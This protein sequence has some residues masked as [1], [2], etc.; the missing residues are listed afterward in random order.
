MRVV[1]AVVIL[2]VSFP[3]NGC[4]RP[5]QA[6]YA[7]PLRSSWVNPQSRSRPPKLVKA[8]S[9]KPSRPVTKPPQRSKESSVKPPKPVGM[10]PETTKASSA[11]SPP[12]LPQRKSEQPPTNASVPS[13][14]GSDT[15]EQETETEAKAKREGVDSLTHDDID[16]LN[17]RTAQTTQGLLGLGQRHRSPIQLHPATSFE[18]LVIPVLRRAFPADLC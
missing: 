4:S 3:L 17:P 14:E 7:K 13:R 2:A 11:E 16:G 9:V 18:A 1:I 15:V 10:L 12:P 6:A 5:Q 8:R